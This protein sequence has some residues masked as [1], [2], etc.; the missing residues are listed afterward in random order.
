MLGM[1]NRVT[2][3]PLVRL[4]FII[5]VSNDTFIIY[6]LQLH[7]IHIYTLFNILIK[8]KKKYLSLNSI[9]TSLEYELSRIRP[10]L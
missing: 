1:F 6:M 4:G 10:S 7:D 5:P 8:T 3:P 9:R 2:T